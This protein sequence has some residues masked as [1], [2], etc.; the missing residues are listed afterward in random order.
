MTVQWSLRLHL[1]LGFCAKVS[2]YTYHC[3]AHVVQ[4]SA[5]ELRGLEDSKAERRRWHA[6]HEV[7]SAKGPQA[8]HGIGM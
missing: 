6:R 4:K 5:A 2:I 3:M 8:F 7:H 1:I